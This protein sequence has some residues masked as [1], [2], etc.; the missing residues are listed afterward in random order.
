[1]AGYKEPSCSAIFLPNT[2]WWWWQDSKS[3]TLQYKVYMLMSKDLLFDSAIFVP[4]VQPIYFSFSPRVG[5]IVVIQPQLKHDLLAIP[6]PT[7]SPFTPSPNY[8]FSY[9][10][11]I[12]PRI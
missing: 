10:P 6:M 5:L 3:P 2:T 8:P 11:G 12:N 1:M 4:A 7:S 9:I